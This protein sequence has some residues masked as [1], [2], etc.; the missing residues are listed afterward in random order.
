M[1]SKTL[2][3][4]PLLCAL[5][6]AATLKAGLLYAEVVPLNADEAVVGLM[7]RHILQGARPIFFYGQLYLGSLDAWLVAAAFALFGESVLAIRLVQ[8]GLYLGTIATTYWL[9]REIYSNARIANA[10]A[11]FVAVPTVNVTLYTTVT[12]GGYGET[13]LIGNIL[14]LLTLHLG[15]RDTRW[16]RWLLFG[17]LGGLGF[18][19]FPLVMVYLVPAVIYLVI[20]RRRPLGGWALAALGFAAG[21]APWWT[22]TLRQGAATVA[23]LS[24][25]AIAG[26]SLPNPVFAF[27]QHLFNFMLLGLTVVFGLRPPWSA[28][29]LALPLAP[30]AL[31]LY[32]TLLAFIARRAIARDPARAGRWLLLGCCLTLVAAFL[33]TP[34]GADPSGR[35]FLPMAAPLALLMAEM[36]HRLYRRQRRKSLARGWLVNGLALGLVVFHGWGTVQG[37]VAFPPGI[38]TQFDEVAQVDQRAIGALIAF[39]RAQGEM[40]GYANYWVGFPLAF[41]SHEELIYEARL[42]YHLDFRYTP[43]DNRYLTYAQVVA[44]S[45]RAAYITTLHPALDARVRVGLAQLGITF[46]EKQIGDFHV[47]YALS[48]KVVPEELGLGVE[49]C[50][51]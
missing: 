45:P 44:A 36:L 25:S 13:L 10:A 35:Y 48:R 37:A 42:P 22:Y 23:E 26:A 46:Q 6:V 34:F 11:L 29:F 9:G 4:R 16:G 24:G 39:L 8:V 19:T 1:I 20:A 14:F 31:A 21:A 15:K 7:A 30:L 41:L 38:T 51:P 2:P 49:C 17:L 32:T 18:W 50:S 5:L 40:R 43:R 12:L 47:F 3:Y 33:L 28:R 27:F